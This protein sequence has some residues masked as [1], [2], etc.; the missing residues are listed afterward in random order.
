MLHFVPPRRRR[1][2]WQALPHCA[3]TL[4]VT[5][6]ARARAGEAYSSAAA[7]LRLK[8][9]RWA[10]GDAH[11]PVAVNDGADHDRGAGLVDGDVLN[12]TRST[13]QAPRQATAGSSPPGAR[14]RAEA[15]A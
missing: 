4:T 5:G 8:L 10:G 9:E 6:G 15:L 2:S 7:A 3:G 14:S 11:A 13:Q 12:W 1:R